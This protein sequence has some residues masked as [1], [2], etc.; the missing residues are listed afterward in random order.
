YYSDL[1]KFTWKFVRNQEIAEELTQDIFIH[2]WENRQTLQ[3]NSALKAYLFTMA[4]NR[5]F[6]YLKSRVARMSVVADE[7]PETYAANA[8]N[9]E[10]EL[11]QQELEKLVAEGI[12]QLPEKCRIVFTLSRHEGLSYQ[13]IAEELQ[14]SPKTVEAHMGTALKKLR[15]FLS[16][17]WTETLALLFFIFNW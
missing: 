6:N 14:I 15:T 5:A 8:Q 2:L 12:E 10:E 7:V 4:R 3:I 17:V 11:S 16:S 13:Q 1:Y 9:P